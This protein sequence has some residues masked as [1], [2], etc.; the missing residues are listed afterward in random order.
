VPLFTCFFFPGD[1][2][3]S[4]RL[5][6]TTWVDDSVR[7]YKSQSQSNPAPADTHTRTQKVPSCLTFYYYLCYL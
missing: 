2:E 6:Q 1:D 3:N 4:T 7:F 5:E